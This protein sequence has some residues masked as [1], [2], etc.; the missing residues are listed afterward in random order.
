MPDEP[1]LAATK[2]S[3]DLMAAE[4]ADMVSSD[5]DAK[6]LDRALIAAFTELVKAG[7]NGAVADVGCGP[8]QATVVLRRL[9]VD[10]FGIDLSPGMIDRLG[11]RG[12][13]DVLGLGIRRAVGVGS[14]TGQSGRG[15]RRGVHRG[16]AGHTRLVDTGAP[17][18][19]GRDA[20]AAGARQSAAGEHGIGDVDH[21]RDPADQG[22]HQ[23]DGNGAVPS[24]V[25]S[26]RRLPGTVPSHRTSRVIAP[27]AD[28]A[29]YARGPFR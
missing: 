18:A 29:A 1:F 14:G 25:R 27:G 5:L 12:P 10:A 3:Y 4:Y 15:H 24:R 11:G 22:Q 26:A 6:P 2:A 19:V 17:A 9:G 8:G 13:C 20:I 28:V 7:G 16:G 21:S 23:Q